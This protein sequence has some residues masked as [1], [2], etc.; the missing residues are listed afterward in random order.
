[1]LAIWRVIVHLPGRVIVHLPVNPHNIQSSPY[2]AHSRIYRKG[3]QDPIPAYTTKNIDKAKDRIN[4]IQQVVGGILYYARA[5]FVSLRLITS[6]QTIATEATEGRVQFHTLDMVL[7]L[8]IHSDTSYLSDSRARSRV[9]GH[10]MLG[11]KAVNGEPIKMND[12]VYDFCGIKNMWLHLQQKPSLGHCSSMQKKARFF[13]MLC[14]KL[15]TSNHQH[16]CIVTMS[17]QHAL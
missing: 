2:E 17:Q 15:D 3:A 8:N 10:F 6:E 11:P 16:Q 12:T 13:T 9:A 1:M 5:V 14:M 4:F 7:N